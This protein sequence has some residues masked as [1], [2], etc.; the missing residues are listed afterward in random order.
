MYPGESEIKFIKAWDSEVKEG[1]LETGS[2]SGLGQDT[3][4][5]C[6]PGCKSNGDR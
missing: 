4:A 1:P 5:H 6:F 3:T 2:R